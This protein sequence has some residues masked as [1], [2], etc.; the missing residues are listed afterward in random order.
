VHSDT[1][2]PDPSGDDGLEDAWLEDFH[3]SIVRGRY[4]RPWASPVEDLNAGLRRR[5]LAR[6]VA[7]RQAIRRR[8]I[9]DAIAWTLML[10]IAAACVWLAVGGPAWPH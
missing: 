3:P 5:E 2:D 9:A 10:A 8:K 6:C 1:F 7:A 4:A